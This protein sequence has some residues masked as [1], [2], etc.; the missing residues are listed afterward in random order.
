MHVLMDSSAL[1]MLG[2]RVD[3]SISG[4]NLASISA[5]S[6]KRYTPDKVVFGKGK[7]IDVC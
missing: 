3:T 2:I 1:L 6:N 4:L 5:C 7:M